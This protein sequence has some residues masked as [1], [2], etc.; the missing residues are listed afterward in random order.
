MLGSILGLCL[1]LCIYST[2]DIPCTCELSMMGLYGLLFMVIISTYTFIVAVATYI[3]C[4]IALISL[5]P[6]YNELMIT[7]MPNI[8]IIPLFCDA[9]ATHKF[10]LH[11]KNK[12]THALAINGFYT[13]GISSISCKID[14]H[15]AGRLGCYFHCIK[16]APLCAWIWVSVDWSLKTQDIAYGLRFAK[17][18]C[19]TSYSPYLLNFLPL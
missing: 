1:E 3:T 19:Q 10:K 8:I 13:Y 12:I 11:N 16:Q 9:L 5:N 18:F 14:G 7:S 15:C 4:S 17:V 6:L 2:I